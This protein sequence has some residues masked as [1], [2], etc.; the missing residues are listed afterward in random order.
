TIYRYSLEMNDFDIRRRVRQR[1]RWLDH[2]PSLEHN[3]K[4]TACP[5][6]PRRRII[7]PKSPYLCL[8]LLVFFSVQSVFSHD[9]TKKGTADVTVYA[10]DPIYKTLRGQSSGA[11]AFTGDYA[12]VNNL[13]LRKDAGI[14]TL[15]SGEIY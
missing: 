11:D 3:A 14:F 2:M 6:A 4:L 13:V 8:M 1:Q 15:G 7:M 5:L 9:E 10:E 12:V